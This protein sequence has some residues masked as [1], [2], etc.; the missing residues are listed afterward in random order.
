MKTSYL[1]V[2]WSALALMVATT[3]TIL[4]VITEH[5]LFRATPLIYTLILIVTGTG[6]GLLMRNRY[7]LPLIRNLRLHGKL[8]MSP[9]TLLILSA[10]A[11]LIYIWYDIS[12]KESLNLLSALFTSLA[13]VF[14]LAFM[15]IVT[16]PSMAVVL[17]LLEQR[18]GRQERTGRLTA[19]TMTAIAALFI[20]IIFIRWL[21]GLRIPG[22][23][24]LLPLY[25]LVMIILSIILSVDFR[26]ALS[27][28]L[29]VRFHTDIAEES[30]D[31]PI[32]PAKGFR[33]ALLFAGD[34]LDLASGRLDYL[35]NCADEVYA[36]EV[37]T[38][39]GKVFDPA[40]LPALRL[41]ASANQFGENV[42]QE[43]VAVISNVEKYYSD[44]VRNADLLRLPG[45]SEKT[46][47]ARGIMLSRREPQVQ[48]IVKL[49]G[50]AD[51]EIR[52]TGIIAAGRYGISE[53]R[54]EVLQALSHHE[55][56]REGFSVLRHFGPD[57]FADLIG[58]A[59]RT[60]NSEREN[61]MIMRLLEMMPLSG[62]LQYLNR[63]IA[64][65]HLS[66]RFKAAGYLCRKGYVP[67]GK[68]REKVE[69]ILN[70]TLHTIARLTA[71]EM[72]AKR[73]RYFILSAALDY[74]RSVNT[75]FII[76][77]VTLLVGKSAAD[78]IRSFSD[79]GTAYGAGIA[80]EALDTVAAGALRKPLKALLGNNTDSG[81][82]AELSLFY[83]LREIKGR[84]VASFILASEQNITGIW[85]KACALHKVA[86]EGGGIDRELAVSYLF[87]NSQLLQ[88]ESARAIRALNPE[89]YR[90]AESRLPEQAR[91]RISAIVSGIAP[92]AAMLFEKTRF[93]SLCFKRIPEEKTVILAS[94]VRYSESYDAESLPGIISW[95]VP[96]Q[97]GKSGHYSLPVSD[98]A[99][100]VFYYSEYT[101]IFVHYMDNQGI[102]AVY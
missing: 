3:V 74:E 1:W 94:A 92:D 79:D 78:V 65:G 46:A 70:M 73:N 31:E 23:V 13:A 93:L 33:S 24:L 26:N 20:I 43:A 2:F 76:S 84:S 54:G 25:A 51:P 97:N 9:F 22:L 53:L 56:A 35:S 6:L 12:G 83:P 48:E 27:T 86:S 80:A 57:L 7:Y 96:S 17:Y 32:V 64:S 72:E 44:P 91:N 49:M 37:V 99:D 39:A 59:L 100:F 5:S 58:T 19:R 11:A 38:T 8:L 18:S 62:A 42:R 88:E 66:I 71:L 77:L 69:E 21:T 102:V 67:Q 85:T 101:D 16:L 52:R 82:L 28:K 36:A 29:A 45:I 47:T 4:M 81:R 63:F 68:Q 15:F 30:S 98:I 50:D 75:G 61:L 10:P 60:T 95:I 87:S 90:D 55:T 89:W 14:F 34:Y 41:I 40:L